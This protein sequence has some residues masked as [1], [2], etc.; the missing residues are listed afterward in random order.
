MSLHAQLTPEAREKLRKQQRNATISSAIIAVLTVLLIGVV[1]LFCLLPVIDNETPEIV[2]YQAGAEEEDKPTKKEMSR[3]VERK[4]SAP[5]SAMAKVIAS[6]SISN[7]AIPVPENDTPMPSLDLGNGDDFG[8]GWG[9]GEDWGTGS[10]QHFLAPRSMVSVF[11][12]SST[13][14]PR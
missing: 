13:I 2:S 11:S 7:I 9:T 6:N 1:L 3:N 8:D 10:G 12:I 4:P 14:Q 5:S